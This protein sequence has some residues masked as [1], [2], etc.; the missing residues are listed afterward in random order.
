MNE[1]IIDF[2]ADMVA[3]LFRRALDLFVLLY[4]LF[5]GIVKIGFIAGFAYMFSMIVVGFPC[6]IFESITKKKVPEEW[7]NKV[8]ATITIFVTLCFIYIS[9]RGEYPEI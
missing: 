5:W 4:D 1:G 6:S 9:L 7:Q 2:T 8:K 3:F